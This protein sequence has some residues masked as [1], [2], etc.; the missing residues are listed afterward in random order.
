MEEVTIGDGNPGRYLLA[1]AV[2]LVSALAMAAT[3]LR[4]A[5]MLL[6]EHP[7]PRLPL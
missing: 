1:Y 6:E 2:G 4:L 7:I 5:S 3:A